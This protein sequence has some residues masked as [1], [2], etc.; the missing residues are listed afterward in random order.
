MATHFRLDS[1]P[2]FSKNF[3]VA[4]LDVIWLDDV[5]CET[6][7]DI[8][9]VYLIVVKLRVTCCRLYLLSS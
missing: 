1:S 9:N 6:D 7:Q 4:E 5:S 2:Q 3:L 8:D